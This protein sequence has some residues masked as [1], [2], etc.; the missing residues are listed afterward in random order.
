MA[1]RDGSS[2]G[3]ETKRALKGQARRHGWRGQ[4]FAKAVRFVQAIPRANDGALPP[5][6]LRAAWQAYRGHG[7]KARRAARKLAGKR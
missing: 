3:N 1:H 5:G 2:Y 4:S 7:Y 6:R